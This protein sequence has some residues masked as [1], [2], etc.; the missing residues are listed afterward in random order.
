MESNDSKIFDDI[1]NIIEYGCNKDELNQE[2][3][4]RVLNK[5]IFKI[6][7]KSLLS[8]PKKKNIEDTF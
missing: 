6:N 5:Y 2:I 4:K 8:I 3:K 1:Q 7:K